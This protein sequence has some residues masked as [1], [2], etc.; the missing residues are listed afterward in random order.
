MYYYHV[1]ALLISKLFG[2]TELKFSDLRLL[3]EKK[4]EIRKILNKTIWRNEVIQQFLALL[5]NSINDEDILIIGEV[6]EYTCNDNENHVWEVL[7]EK[8]F[9]ISRYELA[10]NIFKRGNI[11]SIFSL[12]ANLELAKRK[13]NIE[14]VIIWLGKIILETKMDK[15]DEILEFYRRDKVRLEQSD[16]IYLWLYIYFAL[17]FKEFNSKTLLSLAIKVEKSFEDKE[18]GFAEELGVLLE[19]FDFNSQILNFLIERWAK[20]SVISGITLNDFN[21]RYQELALVKSLDFIPFTEVEIENIP[22]TPKDIGVN[23]PEHIRNMKIENFRR[24]KRVQVSN[25]GMFNLIVGDNNVGK[26]SLLEALL[27]TPD[28]KQYLQ[29]LAFSYIERTNIHPDR[30]YTSDVNKKILYFNLKEDFL[31]EFQHCEEEKN[32]IGFVVKNNRNKWLYEFNFTS[33]IDTRTKSPIIDFETEDFEL[34]NRLPYSLGIKQ[35]FMA[36]GK[37][38]SDDLAAVYDIEIRPKRIL[39]SDFIKNMSLFIPRISQIFAGGT[40]IDIRDEDFPEDRPLHQYG[41]GANKLFRVLILLTLHKGKRLMID[42]IDA[43]IHY[44]KFKQFWKLIIEIA[45]RDKTQIFATTHND[46]CIR[47]FSEVLDDLDEDY[48]KEARVVQMKLVNNKIK[49]RS[50][51]YDS[52][53]LAIEEGVEI[54]GGQI[55]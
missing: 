45:K 34:L 22:I 41:E 20:N 3:N 33:K 19:S 48:Q 44:S 26:T 32:N 18:G 47:Y 15:F 55:L 21:N 40:T 14:E 10:I 46:E 12:R 53:S 43:G 2:D 36:Y 9:E 16:N 39:E 7:G 54:R 37:G 8:Y 1:T 35:P 51:E 13:D 42:E 49:I 29:R 24:F 38:F 23:P 30:E 6:L 4:N 28:K 31:S 17:L 11:Q 52:F 5:E 27:F 50:Y 25:L